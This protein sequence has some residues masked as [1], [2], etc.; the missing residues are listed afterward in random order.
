MDHPIHESMG[1]LVARICRCHRKAVHSELEKVGLHA[2]QEMF[3]N[4]LWEKEGMTQSELVDELGVQPATVSKMLS[5]IEN[6]GWVTKMKDETD[7]RVSRVHLTAEGRQL[8]GPVQAAWQRAENRVLENFTVE[9][10]VLLRR[11][12]MQIL[13][14]LSR[15]TE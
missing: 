5:R 4:C 12:L 9:E 15:E 14:N 8:Q 1:Y 13:D 7:S 2:G 10:K 3:M 6:A 11:F